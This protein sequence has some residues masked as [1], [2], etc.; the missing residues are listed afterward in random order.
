MDNRINKINELI[1]RELGQII[2]KEMNFSRN[3]LVTII[4]VETS[5]DL[6]IAHVYFSV[7]PREQTKKIKQNLK[8]NIYQLQQKLNERLRM[9]PIPKIEFK[10][11]HGTEE[12]E[13]IEEI[14][15]E[16]KVEKQTKI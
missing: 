2:L 9:K 6:S 7:I 12:A 4:K 1:K 13:R 15:E 16:I 3:I 14:F 10:E 11:I 5:L 8:G